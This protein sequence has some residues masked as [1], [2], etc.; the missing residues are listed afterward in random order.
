MQSSRYLKT[1]QQTDRTSCTLYMMCT[2][3]YKRFL[4]YI[5]T[6]LIQIASPFPRFWSL[7]KW[8]PPLDQ[9]SSR[10]PL[11]HYVST[12]SYNIG[13]L[14]LIQNFCLNNKMCL[15]ALTLL[16]IYSSSCS[17][18]GLDHQDHHQYPHYS[19]NSVLLVLLVSGLLLQSLNLWQQVM[20]FQ[21]SNP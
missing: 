18:F 11:V 19:S 4:L 10:L 7:I 8:L 1:D 2:Y 20:K 16:Y 6:D 13:N 17:N 21:Q 15:F 9:K 12:H 14:T 5:S 3:V